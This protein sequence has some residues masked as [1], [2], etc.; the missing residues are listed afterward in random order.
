MI[1]GGS[2]V[3]KSL[4]FSI[5]LLILAACSASDS[6]G[7]TPPGAV[8]VSGT[9][10]NALDGRAVAEAKITVGE[11]QVT[12]D[13][14]GSFALAKVPVGE[15][16]LRVEASAFQVVERKIAVGSVAVNLDL[17]LFPAGA[18][19]ATNTGGAGGAAAPV[20]T[21]LSAAAGVPGSTLTLTGSKFGAAQAAGQVLFGGVSAQVVT[22]TD[23][24]ISVIVPA[25]LAPG[26]VSVV[27]TNGAAASVASAFT[28]LANTVNGPAVTGLSVGAGA[29]GSQVTLSGVR[30]GTAQGASIVSFGGIAAQVLSWTDTAVVAVVPPVLVP[31][32]VEVIVAAGGKASN[33]V[34][35]TVVA[36]QQSVPTAPSGVTAQANGP[37]SVSVMWVD[38]A[39]N[40]D[41]FVV[42]RKIGAGAF[43]TVAHVGANFAQFT[44]FGVDEQLSYTYRIFAVNGAGQS[45]AS[46]AA[47]VATSAATTGGGS[48]TP[49]AAPASLVASVQTAFA[50]RLTWTSNS[51]GTESG[52]WIQRSV[53]GG[54]FV[55]LVTA[56]SG[57][58]S[59]D[60]ETVQPGYT[61]AYRVRAF[62]SGGNSVYV[63]GNTV[64]TPQVAPAA[65]GNLAATALGASDVLLTWSDY[66]NNETAYVIE[67]KAGAGSFMF[68]KWLGADAT[69]WD[70]LGALP[71]TAYTYRVKGVNAAGASPYSSSAAAYTPDVVPAAPT[72][73]GAAA[74]AGRIT[75]SWSDA[76]TN[77]LGFR[78]YRAL[79]AGGAALLTT[80]AAGVQSY[81]D[82]GV[83]SGQSYT[84]RVVAFNTAGE[85]AGISAAATA[86]LMPP[87]APT[88]LAVNYLS[89]S[90]AVLS[91]TNGANVGTEIRLRRA[92]G[93]N[94]FATVA[95]LAPGAVYT[96]DSGLLAET[97][98]RWQIVQ[99]STAGTAASAVVS[100]TMPAAGTGG[101]GGGGGT[102][103]NAP[104]SLI[105]QY[106]A[107]YY[108]GSGGTNGYSASQAT[109]MLSNPVGIILNWLDNSANE[110]GF[111]AEVRRGAGSWN[112]AKMSQPNTTFDNLDAI[113]GLLS[114]RVA[115]YNA[116]GMSGYSNVATLYT[117][118]A[119]AQVQ[120][121]PRGSAGVF[122]RWDN[123]SS[124]AVN[125]VIERSTDNANWSTLATVAAAQESYFDATATS[126]AHYYYR[127][128]SRDGLSRSA[129]VTVDGMNAYWEPQWA[130]R[131]FHGVWAPSASFAVAVG[132]DGL[133]QQFNGAT[134][135]LMATPTNRNLRAV[136]GSAASSIW[137]GG[138]RGTLLYY[139]G[140][141]WQQ[142][143]SPVRGDITAMYGFSSTDVWAVGSQ[144]Y[145]PVTGSL[146]T[147][148]LH[149]NGTAWSAV[150]AP[151]TDCLKAVWGSSSSDVWAVGCLGTAVHWNGTSWAKMPVMNS[152]ETF[153][154]V[155]G[156]AWND[157]YIA[158]QSGAVYAYNGSTWSLKGLP[159]DWQVSAVWTAPA[160]PLY[161]IVRGEVWAFSSNW[162]KVLANAS[163][164]RFSGANDSSLFAVG[165]SRAWQ[166]T[167][168]WSNVSPAW[169]AARI[170]GISNARVVVQGEDNV[171]GSTFYGYNG[172][173][174]Q[175]Y[176]EGPYGV[177]N[178]SV[179]DST[180]IW[181]RTELISKYQGGVWSAGPPHASNHSS[182][183]HGFAFDDITWVGGRLVLDTQLC[184]SN[185]LLS[186]DA[187]QQGWTDTK[188]NTWDGFHIVGSGNDLY[189]LVDGSYWSG[190]SN[191]LMHYQR[192][193]AAT[194]VA[195]AR[196][197]TTS[198]DQACA[199]VDGAA[200]CWGG[201]LPQVVQGLESGVTAIAVGDYHACAIVN[202]AA[203]CWGNNWSGQLGDG[204]FIDSADAA[205][206]VS[207]L[208]SGVSA[209]AIGGA[210]TCAIVSGAAKCWGGNGSGQLGDGTMTDQGSPVTPSGLTANVTGIAMN[211]SETCGVVNGA[212]KCWG[213]GPLGN[214]TWTNSST[215]VSVTGIASGATFVT[216]NGS[217]VCVIVSGAA[218]CWGDNG[219]GQLGNGNWSQQLTPVAVSGLTSGVSTLA[220]NGMSTCAIQSGA[221]KCWGYS[222]EGQVGDGTT[223]NRS[224]P[225]SVSGL[226]SG[227]SAVSLGAYH[228]CALVGGAVKCWGANWNGQ[229][230]DGTFSTRLTPV[231]AAGI[232]SGAAVLFA[233]AERTFAVAGGVGK[234][235]GSNAVWGD[236]GALG[237]EFVDWSVPSPVKIQ[238][239]AFR[240][241]GTDVLT[242]P[243]YDVDADASGNVYVITNLG[244][245]YRR[246]GG[247]YTNLGTVS[248]DACCQYAPI[249]HAAR[250]G[251][252]VSVYDR[253]TRQ[254]T[255]FSGASTVSY[256]LATIPNLWWWDSDNREIL[257]LDVNNAWLLNGGQ[258]YRLR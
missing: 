77:E 179:T 231:T 175:A 121:L 207:G 126:R 38:N 10:R 127:L 119:P 3:K 151:T 26:S 124:T 88:N 97:A 230:G 136:W 244:S 146:G 225:T 39:A 116:G 141:V 218:K 201:F 235:W 56:A 113:D 199:I 17:L 222:G 161:A 31:G 215:P 95:T 181:A 63:P 160:M 40:E 79:G 132:D 125:V 33:A 234:A 223:T 15:R 251:T 195:A 162:S 142:V 9:V 118:L 18:T 186:F 220:G 62:N 105:A 87:D 90:Q 210:S 58:T 37:F 200:V 130:E 232:A 250:A 76:A 68:V 61:Y 209:I 83:V 80:T 129:Y 242:E 71:G 241:V 172:S 233:A 204:S 8:G 165:Y 203:K 249:L 49:P 176:A 212:V 256:E 20:L 101:G 177:V 148:L 110:F 67:R 180:S 94:A 104:A 72:G 183:F 150:A 108:W 174:W 246:D 89:S 192:L 86:P 81:D 187:D 154:S 245:V 170:R 135:T 69:T 35:Y 248:I 84:Y 216:V 92:L 227:V 28:V 158:G 65:P 102:P 153:A 32:N 211:S 57:Q 213:Y 157:V 117:L 25:S 98:Y 254:L 5:A 138:E 44:D 194:A 247:T 123:V 182:C 109:V 54:G 1:A 60:D 229:L 66:A 143:A 29:A 112:T 85:S 52:F 237:S 73:L 13:Q 74:A 11:Q 189:T 139:N 167:A 46:N 147:T 169:N 168:G 238:L 12:T 131:N 239:P 53:N 122:L 149:F 22:W 155:S 226:T 257:L 128:S 228:T 45:A 51:G 114:F 16:L 252:G 243:I 236:V 205:V 193:G 166:R 48:T 75:L 30:F 196:S 82:F 115:T 185:G 159:F 197:T 221:L 140:S 93:A 214:G 171:G 258:V 163:V 99:Y 224:T 107:E 50:V 14:D 91:W 190:Y 19:A 145:D 70:D 198:S 178:F 47:V 41:G 43:A 156:R 208:T 34:I 59:Y 217:V 42:E 64:A 173:A 188:I 7:Y 133:I 184:Y 111:V 191:E 4:L 219:Y 240:Y 152:A 96:A 23:T 137:A 27:V 36:A 255:V 55:W 134:W 253:S 21:S 106:N 164:E 2:P 202:G 144:T 6:G 78:I 24:A 120:Y 206:Q 103:P 100:L